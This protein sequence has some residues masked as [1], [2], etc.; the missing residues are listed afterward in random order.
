MRDRFALIDGDVLVYQAGFASDAAAKSLYRQKHPEDPELKHFN[1]KK[2]HEPVNYT[3]HGTN[4]L[5]QSLIRNAEADD[6]R[7]FV[8]HPVNYREDFFRDYKVNRNI[9]HKPFWYTEIKDYL[10]EN[11]PTEYSEQGD[12]ADDAMG[13]LQ[14][15]LNEDDR[16]EPIIATIDKDLDMIPGLHYNFS[17]NR[18]KDGI[19]R[20]DD[21]EGLQKFYTQILTGDT[22]DNIPGMFQTLGKKCDMRY[23]YPIEGMEDE[24]EMYEY[25]LDVFNGDTKHITSMGKLLWIKRDNRWYDERIQSVLRHGRVR[26]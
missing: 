22:S 6:Y 24:R 16:L 12:E 25:V 3:L 17:K 15:A 21:P 14:C 7:I 4:E 9:E 19:Y 26:I 10:F 1:I 5:I 18:K 2:H 23:Q 20:V 8:S 13:I 11:H